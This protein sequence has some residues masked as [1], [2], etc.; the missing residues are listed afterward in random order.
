MP[1]DICGADIGDFENPTYFTVAAEV[2]R[3]DPFPYTNPAG[4]FDDVVDISGDIVVWEG[5]GDIYAADVSDLDN[6]A[7]FAVCDHPARQR[8]PAVCGRFV[9]WTDERNDATMT[10]TST[11]PTSPTRRLSGNSPWPKAGGSNCSL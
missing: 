10:V 4:D 1:Y 2:G 7:I 9:V 6:I 11:A 8:D 3:R 5:D